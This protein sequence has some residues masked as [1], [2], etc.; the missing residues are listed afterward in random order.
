MLNDTDHELHPQLIDDVRLIVDLLVTVQIDL[1]CDQVHK[2]H[3]ELFRCQQLLAQ[4]FEQGFVQ[5]CVELL[6]AIQIFQE[7]DFLELGKYTYD[8]CL[9][10][11]DEKIANAANST[12]ELGLVGARQQNDGLAEWL[13]V[14]IDCVAADFFDTLTLID[15]LGLYLR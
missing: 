14:L 3:R 11:D 9:G 15:V 6:A 2:V 13:N 10:I 5:A 12:N 8:T 7:A 1:L 4:Y